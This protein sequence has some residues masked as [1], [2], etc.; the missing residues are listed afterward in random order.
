MLLTPSSALKAFRAACSGTQRVFLSNF[1]DAILRN[2]TRIADLQPG[3]ENALIA[4]DL[5]RQA[6]TGWE[7]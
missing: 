6:W 4:S 7:E 5:L 2:G 1:R 3:N